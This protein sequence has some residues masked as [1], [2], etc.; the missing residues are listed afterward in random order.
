MIFIVAL[1]H[2]RGQAAT[3]KFRV[4]QLSQ[5]VAASRFVKETGAAGP[6]CVDF[7]DDQNMA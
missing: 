3:S 6:T 2:G 4:A 5:V 1:V 7:S